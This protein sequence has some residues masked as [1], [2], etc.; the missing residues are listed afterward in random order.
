MDEEL[1]TK[2]K[3]A[4]GVVQGRWQK[5][6]KFG[7][8]TYLLSQLFH[9][10]EKSSSLTP[11]IIREGYGNPD[12]RNHILLSLRRLKRSEYVGG[13]ESPPGELT[14]LIRKVREGPKGGLL[15][16][17]DEEDEMISEALSKQFDTSDKFGPSKKESKFLLE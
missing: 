5:E 1:T 7:W 4:K 17:N 9:H 14:R 12:F 13:E 8:D 10:R 11:K 3:V 6:R 15:R 16:F 2:E